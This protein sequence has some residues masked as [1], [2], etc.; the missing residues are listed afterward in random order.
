M[1][2]MVNDPGYRARVYALMKREL[3]GTKGININGSKHI[4]TGTVF[5][6]SDDNPSEGGIPYL[7]MC[8]GIQV[9]VPKGKQ[10][11]NASKTKRVSTAIRIQKLKK[12]RNKKPQRMPASLIWEKEKLKYQAFAQQGYGEPIAPQAQDMRLKVE[13]AMRQYEANFD[14][15]KPH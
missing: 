14:Y 10:Q 15:S 6:L 8:D 3:T 1:E 2:K 13:M 9:G 12:K 5:T 4:L 11:A 7:G